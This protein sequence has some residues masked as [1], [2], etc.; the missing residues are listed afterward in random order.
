MPTYYVTI[1]IAGH[2]Y[3][4]VEADNEDAALEKGMEDITID[5]IET[6]EPMETF[7]EGNVLYCPRPWEAEIEECPEDVDEPA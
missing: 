1:P 7:L 6:W 3:I 4:Y 5:N 2:A